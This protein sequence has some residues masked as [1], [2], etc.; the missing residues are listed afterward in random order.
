MTKLIASLLAVT[1]LTSVSAPS[2]AAMNAPWAKTPEQKA[3]AA[4]VTSCVDSPEHHAATKE[5]GRIGDLRSKIQKV[6]ECAPELNALEGKEMDFW[7]G[8]IEQI[9][10][11]DPA[12]FT[13]VG[14]VSRA[15]HLKRALRVHDLWASG[16]KER[17]DACKK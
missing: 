2:F 10:K 9:K 17:R 13:E 3:F 4:T 5:L 1:A 8:V 11:M 7:V 6:N 16:I 14:V 15:E 12:C